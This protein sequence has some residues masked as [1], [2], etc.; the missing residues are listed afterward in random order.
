MIV[1]FTSCQTEKLATHSEGSI[2]KKNISFEEFKQ[3]TGI[4]NFDTLISIRAN[5]IGFEGRNPDGSYS[6][7]DFDIDTDII[8]SHKY[9]NKTTYTFAVL[10]IDYE[11]TNL[12]NL[13]YYKKNNVWEKYIV[14]MRPTAENLF[15]IQSGTTDKFAGE[16]R[17]IYKSEPPTN[18]CVTVTFVEN[19]CNGCEGP[20]SCSNSCCVT[21]TSYSNCEG[22]TA[23]SSGLGYG[24]G[25]S[26]GNGTGKI[27]Y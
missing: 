21:T 3:E 10:P 24:P 22:G 18:D 26:P 16:M 27:L 5:T 8:K 4:I 15:Q 25:N 7:S 14:E 23:G 19:H 12:F 9:Q 6:L 2:Y 13:I 17:Q 20:C 11:G 1:V